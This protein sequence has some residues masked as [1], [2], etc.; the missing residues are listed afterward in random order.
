MGFEVG[1]VFVDGMLGMEQRVYFSPED[2]K[3]LCPIVMLRRCSF[4]SE[5]GKSQEN[6]SILSG[7]IG[8]GMLQ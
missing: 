7:R 5:R 1:S 2:W 6:S 3:S 8:Q 4:A